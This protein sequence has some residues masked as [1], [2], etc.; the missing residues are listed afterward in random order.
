MFQAPRCVSRG[1][2]RHGQGY[3]RW[4]TVLQRRST[5]SVTVKHTIDAIRQRSALRFYT[6]P[7]T[8]IVDGGPIPRKK[9]EKLPV[10]SETA[11]LVASQTKHIYSVIGAWKRNGNMQL[12]QWKSQ[13]ILN[14]RP[15]T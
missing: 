5:Q 12:A 9:E 6:C 13:L 15:F 8:A 2:Q 3:V 1:R 4:L 11:A 7:G 10:L 14:G